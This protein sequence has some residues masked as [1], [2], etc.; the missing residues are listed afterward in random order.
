MADY[1]ASRG[2]LVEVVTPDTKVSESVGGTTFP[3]FY[4][5]LYAQQVLLTPNTWLERVSAEG[6]KR[7]ALLRNEYTDEREEREVDQI[8]IENGITRTTRCTRAQVTV[9]QPGTDR[10]PRPVR[11]R[12]A[13]GLAE[14][15]GGGRF[16][17]FRVGDCVSMHNIHGAIYDSLRLCKDF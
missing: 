17:L 9:R 14:P 13:T 4:R 8:V 7:I 1:I 12:T 15:T 2:G 16:L 3:I 6:D 5:R 10:H 11:G